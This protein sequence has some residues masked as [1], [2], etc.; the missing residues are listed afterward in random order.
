MWSS[1]ELEQYQRHLSLEDFGEVAQKNL[2]TSSAL[3]IGAGGLGCPV[4]QYLVAAGVG[5]IGIIDDDKVEISNLQ[6][7]ILFSHSDVGK[8]K[9]EIVSKKLAELNPLIKIE[10]YCE[11]FSAK[12]A[13]HLLQEYDLIID[14]TDNFFSRYLINDACVL[15][16]RPLIHGSIN[17]FEGMV[18]VFNYRKGPTLRC[19]FP[20]CPDS[21]SVPTCAEAGVL[22]VLPG[23]IGC[24]QALESIKLLGKVGEVLSG[25]VLIYDALTQNIRKLQLTPLAKS[26]E[27]QSLP[28]SPDV[29]A[30]IRTEVNSSSII[31]EIS[32]EDL[33]SMIAVNPDLKLLDVRESWEREQSQ[34]SPSIH[35][36]L[37][38]LIEQI[39]SSSP[40]ELDHNQDLVVYCKAGVRSRVACQ[41]LQSVGYTQL[42]NLSCGIDGWVQ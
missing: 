18:T 6:R 26:R 33:K 11:K 13:E 14:G 21:S 36:P 31:R 30:G 34:I 1:E 3:I 8:L 40:L 22:G 2:T 17:R 42:Y 19:L 25:K 16:D 15:F 41:A 39:S 29:C 9:A 23:I 28:T 37:G 20:D 4:L 32:E 27:I 5:K 35:Q 10:P 38:K 7:Q 12:N 24:W